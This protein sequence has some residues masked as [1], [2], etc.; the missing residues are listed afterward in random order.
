M[1]FRWIWY[2][3]LQTHSGRYS[4]RNHDRTGNS[5]SHKA[6]TGTGRAAVPFRR[7]HTS[8]TTGD[9]RNRYSTRIPACNPAR[10]QPEIQAQKPKKTVKKP[11]KKLQTK[12]DAREI[13]ARARKRLN[14]KLKEQE[15]EHQ[16]QIN[17]ALARMNQKVQKGQKPGGSGGASGGSASGKVND[18]LDLYKMV[19]SSAIRQNW[20]FNETMTRI[21]QGLETRLRI[22]IL[23]N[24]EIRD[25]IYEKPSGNHYLDDSAKKAIQRAN[26]FP[27]LPNGMKSYTIGVIFT[28]RG[29]Q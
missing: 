25:I 28:P 24:G 26:P 16:S 5:P 2:P 29:L 9:F 27:P 14:Q 13:L 21:N 3:F 6:R 23:Q 4:A 20:I 12:P 7:H 15:Q 8:R 19:L 17:Q 11:V 1:R 10:P 22:K 18:A